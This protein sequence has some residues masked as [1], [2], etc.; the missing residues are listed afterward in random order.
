MPYEYEVHGHSATTMGKQNLEK[1]LCQMGAKNWRLV[2]FDP[3]I[4]SPIIFER[5]IEAN[6]KLRDMQL[7]KEVDA[8]DRTETETD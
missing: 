3:S 2:G 7:G 5:K 1:W 8:D 6:Q 4:D